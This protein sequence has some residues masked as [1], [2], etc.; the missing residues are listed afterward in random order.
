VNHLDEVMAD[1]ERV[2]KGLCCY[3]GKTCDCKY[4]FPASHQPGTE[5]TGCPE[6]RAALGL[7]RQL[8]KL[9]V[10]GEA[11][12]TWQEWSDCERILRPFSQDSLEEAE[13]RK[14]Q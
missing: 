10:T 3:T 6:I 9:M 1:L 11:L 5:Q 14:V 12:L 2:R 13:K 8:K 7:L 4:G